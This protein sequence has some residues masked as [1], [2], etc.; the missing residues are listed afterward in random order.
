MKGLKNVIKK[1]LFYG[2]FY[3]LYRYLNASGGNRLLILMYHNMIEDKTAQTNEGVRIRKLNRSQFAAHM[4]V[5]QKYYR[6]VSI[7]QAIDEITEEGNLRRDSVAITFDDGYASVYHIAFPLLRE[8][9]FPATIFLVTDWIN[10]KMS[11]WWE[12]LTHMVKKCNFEKLL[13]MD[14]KKIPGLGLVNIIKDL[15]G[16]REPKGIFLEKVEA[17]LRQKDDNELLE[18][19]RNLKAIMFGDSDYA[20]A[21]VPALSWEEIREM[22]AGGIEFGAHTCSHMNLTHADMELAE[23]EI[24]ESKREIEKRLGKKVKGFAY[25]YGMELAS[26]HRVE[27]IL[28]RHGFEYACTALPGH[29]TDLSDRYSLRRTTLPLTTSTSL[30]ARVLSL[31]FGGGIR[32][33]VSIENQ[34][35]KENCT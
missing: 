3:R 14:D 1:G 21:E 16:K 22:A 8:Y 23:K 10:R 30:S 9:N 11:L 27:P 20:P 25:P 24:V 32:E 2:G 35:C 17:V 7:E 28:K 12:D 31:D 26:Y 15:A 18:T 29:N 33:P 4:S 6:V 19:M 13:A 34:R 5:L